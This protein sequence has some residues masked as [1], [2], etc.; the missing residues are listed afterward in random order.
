MK[1]VRIF[2]VSDIHGHYT[3]LKAALDEAGFECGNDSHL[4]VVVGDCFDRGC[5][6]KAV[7]D[8]LRSVD[9]KVIVR[10]NHEDF[11]MDVIDNGSYD[12]FYVRNGTD[13]TVC[14][15]FGDENVDSYGRIAK[16]CSIEDD[17]RKFVGETYDYFETANYIFTHGWVPVWYN[18][19]SITPLDD[20][21]VAQRKTWEHARF[22]E[23]PKMYNGGALV[24]GKTVVCG[25]R[26]TCLA[27]NFDMKRGARDFSI[28]KAEGLCAIDA[29]TV[30]SHQVNVF[31]TEDVIPTCTVHK[32]GLI[33]D[34]FD[35]VNDGGKTVEM[36][37]YDRKRRKI[38]VGDMIEFSND[39]YPDRTVTCKV[40]GLY[41]YPDFETLLSECTEGEV[42]FPRLPK[43]AIARVMNKI[44]AYESF[45]EGVLAIKIKKI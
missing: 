35:E 2:A 7:F 31:V 6:N 15:L 27:S 22:L 38:K 40:I 29:C 20:W 3:L 16:G 9:N 23:W 25:H 10:G 39:D 44:Y 42:G 4:L 36:R 18:G 30:L 41:R 34:M 14:E 26:A 21:R 43:T 24:K 37:M 28:Y 33:R 45:D 12:G 8:F 19:G 1:H 11:L 17:I 13:I 5:E 32:M